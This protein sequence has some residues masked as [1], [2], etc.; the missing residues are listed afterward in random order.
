MNYITSR[1]SFQSAAAIITASTVYNFAI[2]YGRYI[3]YNDIKILSLPSTKL[4]F[5]GLFIMQNSG[6][7]AAKLIITVLAIVCVILMVVFIVKNKP[8]CADSSVQEPEEEYSYSEDYSV[9]DGDITFEDNNT[10]EMDTIPNDSSAP[11]S[12]DAN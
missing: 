5:G 10:E 6:S 3:I 12:T 2:E 8:E 9:S 7:G 1:Y 4:S 11:S